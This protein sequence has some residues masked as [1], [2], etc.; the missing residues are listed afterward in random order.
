MMFFLNLT[1]LN[2]ISFLISSL[3][4]TESHDLLVLSLKDVLDLLALEQEV[5][6]IKKIYI[7]KI[8]FWEVWDY[9]QRQINTH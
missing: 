4:N 1:L 9:K 5:K 8:K 3:Q 2:F 6:S 7:S